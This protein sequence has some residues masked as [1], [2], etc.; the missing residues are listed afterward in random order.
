MSTI[1]LPRVF[2]FSSQELADPAP[3]LPPL[4]ALRLYGSSFPQLTVAELSE[5]VVKNDR[6]VYEVRKHDI[7][8]KG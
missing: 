7:K 4:E 5:P 3:D 8:T 1:E 6:I 2:K